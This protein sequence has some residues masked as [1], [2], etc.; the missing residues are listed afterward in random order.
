M[1]TKLIPWEDQKAIEQELNFLGKGLWKILQVEAMDDDY[2]I[3][4]TV[5]I[6][7]P[8]KILI[9]QILD[10]F[11]TICKTRIPYRYNDYSWMGVIFHNEKQIAGIADGWIGRSEH[12][13]IEAAN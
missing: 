13:I 12:Y 8:S 2:A 1:S 6:E 4:I 7:K 5:Q 11:R 10:L 9:E 3:L